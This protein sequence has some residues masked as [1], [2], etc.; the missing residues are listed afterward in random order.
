MGKI[1]I[2]K[3]ALVLVI[4][5]VIA[6]SA[7][8]YS[9]SGTSASP[10]VI[11]SYS[12]FTTLM[13]NSNRAAYFKLSCD[14]QLSG[15][16]DW[17]PVGTSSSP[18]TGQFD[19][20]GHTIYIDIGLLP[21]VVGEYVKLTYDRSL[22]GV[23][24]SDGDAIVSLDVEGKVFGYNAGGLV[25][26]LKSGNIR[27]CS[28]SGD[29]TVETSPAGEDAMDELIYELG[30]DDI[31]DANGVEIY[32]DVST[33]TVAYGKINAGGL[34]AVMLGGTIEN[35]SFR[36]SITASADLTSSSAGGIVGRM[37]QD[38]GSISGCYVENETIIT[39]STTTSGYGIIATAGG[40]AGYANTAL[41]TKIESCDF[42]GTV[43]STYYA[44]G[45][46]GEVH[47][48]VLTGNTVHPNST[49]TGSYSAG[50]IAGYMASG[51]SAI[52]NDVEIGSVVSSDGYSAGGIIGLL[53]TNKGAVSNNNSD[54]TISGSASYNGGIVGALGTGTRASVAVGSGNTYS[55]AS[56]GIGR[57]ENGNAIDGNTTSH[58]NSYYITTTSLASAVQGTFYSA[59]LKTNAS[60]GA[61]VTWTYTGSLPDGLSLDKSTGRLSG[62][63]SVV[64][65]YTF[66]VQAELTGSGLTQKQELSITVN[67]AFTIYTAGSLTAAAGEW[68][69]L[70]F[71]ADASLTYSG[72]AIPGLTIPGLTVPSSGGKSL[73]ISGYPTLA[74]EFTFSVEGASGDL[75]ATTGTLTLTVDPAVWITT[76]YIS[77]NTATVGTPYTAS[78]AL[79]STSSAKS[80]GTSLT[81]SIA[82]GALPS[83]LTITGDLSGG[84]ISG[85]PTESGSFDFTAEASLRK[86]V[87]G[88]V[89]YLT[90]SMDYT[91]YV[92]PGL[93]IIT[94]S[95]P[96]GRVGTE[97]SATLSAY[98]SANWGL[99][100][101]RL[102][103]GLTLT[104]SDG[105]GIISGTPTEWGTFPIT[106]QASDSSHTV[107]KDY[108]IYIVSADSS[109]VS[110]TTS[111]TL[112]E[113]KVGTAY[114]YTLITNAPSGQTI[115]WGEASSNLASI[116][117]TLSEAGVLSG[118]PT[119]AADNFQFTAQAVTGGATLTKDFTITIRPS[120]AITIITSTLPSVKAGAYY[121]QTLTTEASA[122]SKIWYVDSGDFPAGLTLGRETGIISGTPTE[123]G[124]YTF[125]VRLIAGSESTT[126][127]FT[128][129]VT[130]VISIITS[131]LPVAKV[132]E[133]YSFTLNA[134]PY[135]MKFT[136]SGIGNLPPGLSLDVAGRIAGTPTIAGEYAFTVQASSGDLT[137]RKDFALTVRPVLSITTS[138]D[139]P[140]V[141]V[142]SSYSCTL[143]TDAAQSQSVYW[144]MTGGTLPSGLTLNSST[145]T[146]SGIPTQEGTFTFTIQ[147]VAGSLIA[148]KEF[149][150]VV[151]PLL[152]I[153]TESP[154]TA[155]KV[156]R[157]YT[158]TFTADSANPVTWTLSDGT[159][160]SG[161][162][163]VNGTLSGTP[164]TAGTYT[165][166][167]TAASAGLTSSK[168]FVMIVGPA[169]TITTTSPLPSVKQGASYSYTLET[170]AGSE[171]VPIWTVITSGDGALPSGL[172]L[173]RTS[174][175]ISGT[176][177]QEGTY[178][179]VIQAQVGNLYAQKAFMLTVRPAISI[180]TE[181]VLPS[182]RTNTEYSTTL[183]TDAEDGEAVTWSLVGG[184]LPYGLTLDSQTGTI[185]GYSSS[186]GSYAFTVMAATN[187][188]SATKDFVLTV[189]G[190][191]F[192]TTNSTLP[193]VTAG[194]PYST[195]L[196]TD[197]GAA[198]WSVVKGALPMGLTLNPQTGT[199]SG[200]PL[201][202]GTYT[203]TVRTV[204]G[205]SSS[206]K[207]F[208]VK[209]GFVIT[210]EI[211]LPDGTAGEPYSYV[212]RSNGADPSLVYWATSS[213]LLP[214]G[215]TLSREGILSGTTNQE[216]TYTFPV[217]AFV[218]SD[219]GA[220]KAM[221]L[222]IGSVSTVPIT[223][224]SLKSGQV[225]KEY[226]EELYTTAGGVIWTRVRG[227]LP[228]GLTLGSSGVIS[229]V[230][231]EAGEF[232]F[233]VQAYAEGR[234]GVR[235][236]TI[237]I[238]PNPAWVSPDVV[239]E[240]RDVRTSSGGGGGCDSGFGILA[241]AVLILKR[242]R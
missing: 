56:Y 101:G 15:Y 35:S 104:N 123:A 44:G 73:T 226:Y 79:S 13:T 158:I 94:P 137:A 162:S 151:E 42:E 149:R 222:T 18:F 64:G 234:E 122:D 202:A 58:T 126:K 110:I 229:G 40:I 155:G 231:T 75:R 115:T 205:Y 43:N 167:L 153:L 128:L 36:G 92:V 194:T 180:T 225:G 1:M 169:L 114:S 204:S 187:R 22:F 99:I 41:T 32:D 142:G 220:Q 81:W 163:L 134:S 98:S 170:D 211:N 105:S 133:A 174:G 30:D 112:P 37:L 183:T 165:F 62:V 67:N 117:L 147:A 168:E 210:S 88:V 125:R 233:T 8:A 113:G 100:S 236:F 93:Y 78:I 80:S 175:T 184:S 237:T 77:P 119:A 12:D 240:S 191:V 31:L 141:K 172:S 121:S 2:R 9:G 97:Y 66:T 159:L 47:G 201:T 207:D 164:T 177:T 33:K 131:T 38:S 84:R 48:T 223:N 152:A 241:L 124:S 118:T 130:P 206:E 242:P 89:V 238:A 25:S 72:D 120:S 186:E 46:A 3:F 83:G 14:I 212:M 173:H 154:L 103:A 116:G 27:N 182:V 39:A 111:S 239:P 195:T 71:S 127:V 179:F 166:T 23:V 203:F 69:S 53:E 181:S 57:D 24:E 49:I 102:P 146:I 82:D 228:T 213:D 156:S 178:S 185:S 139:L 197:S 171:A 45:I 219:I 157:Y 200:T 21:V 215:I 16:G 214:A 218:S 70:V 86:T 61:A 193:A 50:G 224:N 65:T 190:T 176:P 106:V 192:I 20:Q 188:L 132:A 144:Y 198:T 160:P 199:I 11:E 216:G 5:C 96:S 232:T 85:T 108:S 68:Y 34:V 19:G 161:L 29:I 6:G 7:C 136:W 135:S 145:G 52:S 107:T 235:E 63:P 4:L 60:S 221:R 196:Q 26:I 230:P 10:Y 95:L 59:D 129:T 217:Y 189:G 140:N 55:G 109:A 76:T 208:T 90:D 227:V 51:G 87:G 148:G 17:E 138:A 91:L 54:A 74:G 143:Q 150:L 28:F 209:V